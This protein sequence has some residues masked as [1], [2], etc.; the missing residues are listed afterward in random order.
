MGKTARFRVWFH[1]I[2]PGY[3][4]KLFIVTIEIFYTQAIVFKAYSQSFA[5]TEITESSDKKLNLLVLGGARTEPFWVA[6]DTAVIDDE[7]PCSL[8]QATHPA[9]FWA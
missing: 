8:W 3:R 5:V 9:R 6:G 4:S 2:P 1:Y 7:L